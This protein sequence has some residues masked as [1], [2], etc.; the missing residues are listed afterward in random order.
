MQ[1]PPAQKRV[2]RVRSSAITLA[3]LLG[4]LTS[5]GGDGDQ[6][7]DAPAAS[8]TPTTAA[9]ASPIPPGDDTRITSIVDG[10]TIW[11]DGDVKVRLIGID[12]PETRDPAK[13]VECFGEEATQRITELIPPPTPVRLVYDA[14]RVD[15]Y[16]RTLAY[17]YRSSDGLFVNADLLRGGYASVLTVPPNV[18]HSD[19]FTALEQDARDAARGIW[20]AC[21]TA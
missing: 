4:A 8:S 2:R 20:G 3:A 6:P 17:V 9:V 21:D 18:T 15:Q 10:D 7:A 16:G 19:E 14:D 13:P 12:T 1:P 5:C 11:V